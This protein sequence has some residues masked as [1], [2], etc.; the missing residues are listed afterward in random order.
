MDARQLGPCELLAIMHTSNP[1]VLPTAL[2]R[3]IPI[4][5]VNSFE[6]SRHHIGRTIACYDDSVGATNSPG[7]LWD[8]CDDGNNILL[9]CP[10]L[11]KE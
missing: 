11:W 8:I 9:S 2:L 7:D 10:S 3:T 1:T 4:K 6:H 5:H